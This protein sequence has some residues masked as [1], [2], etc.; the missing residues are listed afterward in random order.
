VSYV[1]NGWTDL[2]DMCL[3]KEVPFGGG[4]D[5]TCIKIFSGAN[6]FNRN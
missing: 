2:N 5:C 4:Y 1:N 6:F 3:H